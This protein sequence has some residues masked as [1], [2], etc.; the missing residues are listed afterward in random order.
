MTAKAKAEFIRSPVLEDMRGI[1]HAF[2]TRRGGVSDGIYGSLNCGLGSKD[3]PQR[4]RENRAR[5]AAAVGAD[6]AHLVS[7]FQHHSTDVIAADR[8]WTR[9][10]APRADAIVTTTPGLAIAVSTADCVPVLFADPKTR[11]VGAAHAGWRGALTGVLESTIAAMEKLGAR[12]AAIQASIGPAISARAYEVGDEFEARFLAED[13]GNARYFARS[14][15]GARPYFDLTG[16]VADRLARAGLGGAENLD[17]CTY[18]QA[19]DFF[20]YRRTTHLGEP[21]YGRQISAILLA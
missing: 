5:A 4:V 7:A 11:V 9:E 14:G 18:G 10:T 2:F 8:P 12:R 6:A 17:I 16:Y 15:S 1:T 19:D 20:S 3:D 13:K 21:D